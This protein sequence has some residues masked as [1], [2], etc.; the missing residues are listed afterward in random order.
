MRRVHAYGF[1]I[2]GSF[3]KVSV[4]V[5]TIIPWF[6]QGIINCKGTEVFAKQSKL[7]KLLREL[8]PTLV[9]FNKKSSLVF[10]PRL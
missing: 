10:V 3:S 5:K 9:L 2:L 7:A 1:A 4:S 8:K 6:A